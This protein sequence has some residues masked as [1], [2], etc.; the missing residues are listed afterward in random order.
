MKLLTF[1]CLR[2]YLRDKRFAPLIALGVL[3]IGAG[4]LGT[5]LGIYSAIEIADLKEMHP[6]LVGHVNAQ[7]DEVTADHDDLVKLESLTHSLFESTHA[8]FRQRAATMNKA[9]CV[10]T[11]DEE[12]ILQI[13]NAVK[14]RA[15]L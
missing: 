11:A 1:R 12:G 7:K 2:D 14:I 5:G 8:E 4:L 13:L 3:G 10:T 6:K 9:A 15:K